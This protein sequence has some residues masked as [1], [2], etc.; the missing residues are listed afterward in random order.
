MMPTHWANGQRMTLRQL[1][2]VASLRRAGCRCDL[3]LL[4]GWLD[5]HI[6]EHRWRVRCRLCDTHGRRRRNYGKDGFQ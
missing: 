6:N 5:G 2:L 3:P 1:L 4:G